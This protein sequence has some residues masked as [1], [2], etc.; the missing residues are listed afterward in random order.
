VIVS[1]LSGVAGGLSRNEYGVI[2]SK[3]AGWKGIAC[4]VGELSR[5]QREPS[6]QNC[7]V[8]L[9][10]DPDDVLLSDRLG[11][12][13]WDAGGNHNSVYRVSIFIDMSASFP[14][15]INS[16][17]GGVDQA[18]LGCSVLAGVFCVGWGFIHGILQRRCQD[19][20]DRVSIAYSKLCSTQVKETGNSRQCD[21]HCRCWGASAVR[22]ISSDRSL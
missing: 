12:E 2:D 6:N 11:S 10:S 5:R 21:A 13:G 1:P 7:G 18:M 15:C 9:N 16:V 4:W 20:M 22:M 3:C 19:G 8:L 14:L 17:V